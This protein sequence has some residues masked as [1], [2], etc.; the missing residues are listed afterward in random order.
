[1]ESTTRRALLIEQP[2]LAAPRF[3]TEHDHFITGVHNPTAIHIG[4][5]VQERAVVGP[6]LTILTIQ[7]EGGICENCEGI[8]LE[9]IF[10]INYLIIRY[11]TFLNWFPQKPIADLPKISRLAFVLGAF[12]VIALQSEY[13]RDPPAVLEQAQDPPLF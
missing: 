3:L 12:H 13:S 2:N 7:S 1:M 10:R 9:S 5:A 4:N 8:S 11:S 6:I